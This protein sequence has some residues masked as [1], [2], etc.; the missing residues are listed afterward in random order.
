MQFSW[1]KH[2]VKKVIGVPQARSNRQGNLREDA[3]LATSP[4]GKVY[5]ESRQ[6]VK[7]RE[8]TFSI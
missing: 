8:K 6:N 4:R 1:S 2:L 5:F 3:A 7:H